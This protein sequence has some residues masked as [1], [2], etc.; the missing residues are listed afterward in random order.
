MT[1]AYNHRLNSEAD[2]RIYMSSIARIRD[3]KNIK[4]MPLFLI[5]LFIL[6]NIF[7]KLLF[8]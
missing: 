4:I 5:Q 7:S 8:C 3:L 6:E 2:M 1:C